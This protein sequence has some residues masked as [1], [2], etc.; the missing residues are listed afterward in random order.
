[1]PDGRPASPVPED[2]PAESRRLSIL[3]YLA[4]RWNLRG[5]QLATSALL[6]VLSTSEAAR[7]AIQSLASE[8]GMEQLLRICI[9]T[10]R[11]VPGG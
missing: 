1:M 6:F 2:K 10:T 3:G 8:M 7:Q 5:E 9:L 11:E 4:T